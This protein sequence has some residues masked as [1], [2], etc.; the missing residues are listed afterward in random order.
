VRRSADIVRQH[1]WRLKAALTMRDEPAGGAT[2]G[3]RSAVRFLLDQ[4]V[5][6]DLGY[7][8]RELGH[9]VVRVHDFLP[10]DA[11]DLVVLQAAY[12]H[13]CVLVTCNRN[14]FIRLAERQPHHGIGG[15]RTEA[16][17]T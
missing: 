12:K 4:D 7:L 5:P 16:V 15:V 17:E 3:A 13:G 11:T 2:D 6:E 1:P 9:D 14:D 10:Q 8:L